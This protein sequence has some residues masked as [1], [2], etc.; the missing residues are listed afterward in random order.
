M[1]TVYLLVVL[2]IFSLSFSSCATTVHTQPPKVLVIKKLP[3][4][5]RVVYINGHRYYKWNGKHYR[6]TKRGYVVVKV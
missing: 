1:R 5:H 3:K 6:K 2:F 4:H